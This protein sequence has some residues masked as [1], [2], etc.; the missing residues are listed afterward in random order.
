MG[1]GFLSLSLGPATATSITTPTCTKAGAIVVG[2][3]NADVLTGTPYNDVIYGRGGN[4]TIRGLGGA[5]TTSPG[6]ATTS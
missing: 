1:A 6:T 3:P 2:G 4:D 5:D